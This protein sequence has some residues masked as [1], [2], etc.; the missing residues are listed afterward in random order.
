MHN[1]LKYGKVMAYSRKSIGIG[2]DTLQPTFLQCTSVCHCRFWSQIYF[3]HA[4]QN[5]KKKLRSNVLCY[6]ISIIPQTDTGK[7]L[8]PKLMKVKPSTTLANTPS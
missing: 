3:H 6:D 5:R 1:L 4:E 8:K 2:Y 7:D